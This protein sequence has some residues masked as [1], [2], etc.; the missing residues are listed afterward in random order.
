MP[1]G[2]SRPRSAVD[3]ALVRSDAL[4]HAGRMTL[5]PVLP[6]GADVVRR[7]ARTLLVGGRPGV[8]VPDRPGLVA[9]L[10]LLDGRGLESLARLA[11]ERVPELDGRPE[12]VVH[13]L[14][15]RGA[16]RAGPAPRPPRLA[17]RVQAWGGSAPEADLVRVA[18]GGAGLLPDPTGDAAL[19]VLVA[20]G[21]P[22]RAW[23]ARA[24]EC[25]V[26]VLP[27]VLGETWARVGP[28]TLAGRTACLGCADATRA[29]GDPAWGA[30]APQL[31]RPLVPAPPPRPP[32]ALVHRTAA[33]VV[34]QALQCGGPARPE[35]VGAVLHLTGRDVEREPVRVHPS[36][37]SLLHRDG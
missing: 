36:C 37:T 7:D 6:P 30:V 32:A 34:E 1:A 4:A 28:L 22:S 26:P 35:S 18:L 9:L 2:R 20:A 10:R 23:V 13:E 21:E 11:A 17:W 33:V 19:L 29:D 3:D 31:G 25:G 8:V 16:L 27:V 12:D 15:A 24:V 14:V 5:R